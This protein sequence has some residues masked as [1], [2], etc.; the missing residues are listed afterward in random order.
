[1]LTQIV[2]ATYN[3]EQYQLLSKL[4]TSLTKVKNENNIK[5]LIV[6]NMSDNKEHLDTL[7]R[8]KN[9]EHNYPFEI[10][11]TTN[12]RRGFDTGAYKHGIMQVVNTADYYL[13][14]QDDIEFCQDNWDRTFINTFELGQDS[15]NERKA[16]FTAFCGQNVEYNPYHHQIEWVREWLQTSDLGKYNCFGPMWFINN[17]NLVTLIRSE[18][19]QILHTRAFPLTHKGTH[20]EGMESG[21]ASLAYTLGYTINWVTWRNRGGLGPD[22]NDGRYHEPGWYPLYHTMAKISTTRPNEYLT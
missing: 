12:T 7:E 16:L 10:E 5:V 15:S 22:H 13:F 14:I 1:M 19:Y 9:K 18:Q 11:V 2:V 4:L 6:D 17:T 21:M 3:G 20:Q 8:F